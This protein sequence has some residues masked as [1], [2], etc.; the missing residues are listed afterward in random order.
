MTI[1][2]L[3]RNTVRAARYQAGA[4]AFPGA[5]RLHCARRENAAMAGRDGSKPGRRLCVKEDS[6]VG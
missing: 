5:L 6:S 2:S 1:A 4:L 3:L